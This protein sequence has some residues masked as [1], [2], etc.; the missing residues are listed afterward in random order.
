LPGQ[1]P[2]AVSYAQ[3]LNSTWIGTDLQTLEERKMS[4]ET[5]SNSDPYDPNFL[6]DP[7]L[8]TGKHRT[9]LNLPCFRESIIPFVKPHDLKE[10]LNDQFRQRHPWM[11]P[12][13]T[14]HKIRSL[15]KKL[16]SVA[17]E[18]DCE[19][20]S[21]ALSYVLLDKLLLKNQITKET[22]KLI[23]AVCLVLAVKFNDPSPKP[24]NLKDLLECLESYLGVSPKEVT[25]NEFDVFTKLS[26]SLFV[27]PKE[28]IPHSDRLLANLELSQ[29]QDKMQSMKKEVL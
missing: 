6:D 26:F 24:Q 10:E 7:E 15:K 3:L 21:V 18:S 4:D 1:K 14:L 8:K 9:V 5:S 20:S 27:D 19:I 2:K 17:L 11:Q 12:G 22:L 29:T 16:L 23:G 28:V 13:I 25:A